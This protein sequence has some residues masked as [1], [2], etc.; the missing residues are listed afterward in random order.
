MPWGETFVR[1]FSLNW[2]L[3]VA[4][5]NYSFF[6]VSNG[7]SSVKFSLNLPEDSF[8][9]VFFIP[10]CTGVVE[11]AFSSFWGLTCFV[12]ELCEG[13][14]WKG[15]PEATPGSV[16]KNWQ[17]EPCW[18]WVRESHAFAIAVSY[19]LLTP[20]LDCKFFVVSVLVS[21]WLPPELSTTS[22]TT[23][24]LNKHVLKWNEGNEGS[25]GGVWAVLRNRK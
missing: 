4:L 18:Q 24:V 9:P 8:F 23:D 3:H 20:F 10:T 21:I 16:G 6:K 12:K 17:L 2:D 1:L 22:S 15:D 5:Y 14:Y 11:V 7:A 13:S 25:H 19:G